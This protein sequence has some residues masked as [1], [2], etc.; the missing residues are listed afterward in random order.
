MYS[1]WERIKS[2]IAEF[3]QSRIFVLII[4][5]CI[6]SAIL[7]QRIF[8]LQIVK[9]QEYLDDYK[10]QIQ[11]TK[12]IQGTRGNI[13]DRNGNLLAYNELA[14]SVTIEDNGSYDSIAQ[15]NKV[16]NK[17]ISSVIKMVESNGD[18]VINNFGII[19]DSNN[20]Y[21]FVAQNET[22]KLRFIAD[23][24][25]KSTIDQL[26]KK[27]KATT[28]DELIHY[29]CTDKQKFG[30][31]EKEMD[32][33]TVL[34]L[35]NIR[36]Q[37]WLNSYQKYISTTIAEDVS[38]ATVADIME[39]LDKLSGINVEEESLRKY[40]DSKCF[41]NIIGYTG[42]ISQEE[43]DALSDAD[44][45]RYSKTDTVGK[46]GLE[47][48][49]DSQL[50]GKKGSEKLYVNNV[51]KVIK[52]VK[53]TNPKAGNDLYL[54]IDANLQKAAYNILEQ[55]LAGVL[56]AKIQNSLD[57]DRNKVEDGSD[58]IIP[59]G[60]VYNAMINNDVLDMTHFTD[61]DAGEAE[62]EV[63]SAF[64]IRKEEVKN[65]LTKVLNDSKAAA[66]KDQPKEVQAYLTYLVSDVLTNGTGVLMSKSIDTKDATYKAWKD[67]ESINV[68]T[69]LNYA[70]SKNW[71]DTS[72]LKDY[73]K[74][75][76]QYSD[77]G[78]VYQGII[79]YILD[80]IN[81]DNNF[82]K[83]IYRYMI[84]SGTIT[85]R[86]I[87][88]ML[89]EQNILDKKDNQYDS[90]KAGSIGAYDF[91]R[92]KIQSLEITPGQLGL[93]PC[94]GSLVATDPNTGEVLACV[95]YPGYDN[96]RLV[97]NM[98]TDYYA[99]LSTDK[100]SPFFNKA[101]QQTA[102]PG[103]TFKIL[104]TIAGMS[105]G[106]I[107]DGTYINCTGSF[108]LVTPPINCWNKQGHG[109]IEIREA[110]GQS[111]NSYFNMVG[112]KL[113]QDADGNFSENRSLS[114][115]QKYA[116]E[117]GLD[118]KTGIEITESAPHVS[119]SY[120]VP[121]YIGQGTNAYT[122]SQLARYATAIAT[123][124]NVYDLTL[125]DRQT[126]SKGNTLK[127]YEP[128]IINTVDVSQNVWDDIHDGMYRV[129]QTHRQFDGLGVD[130]AG[131]TGTAEVNVYHPNHGMFVGYAPASDPEYA[132]A[133]RI[134]NGYTSGNACLA[135]DDI[136]KYIFELT[137]EKSI[138]T[139]VAASDTSDT[140]ND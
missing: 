90:L 69:Y 95:S 112:F 40:A 63:A 109:E 132:I 83:L 24:Y 85:G 92:S 68:Y 50:Q 39:N 60:D 73:I 67:E 134:E 125:L 131:K 58:V 36:Y 3:V 15:Q 135:A 19:L 124:G 130:V 49:M 17:T 74:S 1:L 88:M 101:T 32:K 47:K 137:D 79:N 52:T 80:Y 91:I 51:G 127:K 22:Q 96:N 81:T 72:L 117:I 8:Y 7:V 14:Y 99:K 118:K 139:G 78:E 84:K 123:S 115:L 136:F 5:F 70:I 119:D 120:A 140:S 44:Q 30:I 100:S 48:A 28:A 34:K 87:C 86:Q 45:E 66:Y 129:V 55:E 57:F 37:I 26:S 75:N 46:A 2:G 126:D 31:N 20:N 82:D 98:D 114:V 9:G 42:Q 111:C 71:I 23:V 104:S 93:E 107:D 122:T 105:E 10:L 65:T 43:Y 59:I 77:S 113:G 35:I 94:T 133:V 110:I 76:E 16:L 89:Y 13:Y 27:Q 108:D 41:A 103:S 25:G 4:V 12:E 121:S 53:G 33:S 21:Q 116:S 29:L 102:A 61:P 97:N 11:K 62:K 56:L 54:T 18:T 64:S 128:D 38:D 106:V 6:T 138:L